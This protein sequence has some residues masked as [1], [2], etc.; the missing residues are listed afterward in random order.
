M[1][2]YFEKFIVIF[3]IQVSCT[4]HTHKHTFN[5]KSGNKLGLIAAFY[6]VIFYIRQEYCLFSQSSSSRERGEMREWARGGSVFIYHFVFLTCLLWLWDTSHM[7]QLAVSVFF[8]VSIINFTLYQLYFV[9]QSTGGNSKWTEE[10][11]SVHVICF[12]P[13]YIYLRLQLRSLHHLFHF[14]PCVLLT[15]IVNNEI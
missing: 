12:F 11:F 10:P 2:S 14:H 3:F 15:L 9:S 1:T 4:T 5:D 13:L 7:Q 6:Y 8:V